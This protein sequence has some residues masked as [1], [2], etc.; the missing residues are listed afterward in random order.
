MKKRFSEE[1]I[2]NVLKEADSGM[3]I[4]ELCRKH[5][6]AVPTYYAWKAKFGGMDV[7]EAQRLRSLEEENRKL[8]RLV[9]DQA[10]DIMGLKEVRSKKW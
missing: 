7:S 5:N 10:L 3:K 8:K 6:I 9:A 1:Q 4:A 2:I